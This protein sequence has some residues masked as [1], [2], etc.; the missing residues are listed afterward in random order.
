MSATDLATGEPVPGMT[1]E[2]YRYREISERLTLRHGYLAWPTTEEVVE[3]HP[4]E[5][6]VVDKSFIYVQQADDGSWVGKTRLHS[7]V[8]EDRDVE[9]T[10]AAGHTYLAEAGD[11]ITLPDLEPGSSRRTR[12]R[13]CRG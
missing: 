4:D 6:T 1:Y 12:G 5:L 11:I 10:H 9:I 7:G 13:G 3:V 2:H 8:P